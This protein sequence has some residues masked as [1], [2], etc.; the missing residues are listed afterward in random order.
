MIWYTLNR[1]LDKPQDRSGWVR[2]ISPLLG[3]NPRTAQPVAKQNWCTRQK[4]IMELSC[5]YYISLLRLLLTSTVRL[6][7]VFLGAFAKLRKATISFIMSV[8][9]SVRM[10]QLVFHY[11]DFHEV[12]YLSVSRKSVEK[13]QVSLK[14]DKIKG[15]SH[16]D[17][18][19]FLITS[20]ETLLRMRYV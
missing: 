20:R 11:T 17:Q 18:F 10:E 12:W 4:C 16:E 2:N 7:S 1:R 19:T 5:V 6:G 9:Q 3:L 15:T 13:I 14:P 8:R